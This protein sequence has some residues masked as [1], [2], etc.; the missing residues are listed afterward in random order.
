MSGSKLTFQ[1]VPQMIRLRAGNRLLFVY[2]EMMDPAVMAERVPDPEFVCTAHMESQGFI[3]NADGIVS[4]TPR[5]GFEV[6]GVVW[7]VEEIA[8]S[9]LDLLLGVPGPVERFGGFSRNL[10]GTLIVSELPGPR[11][12]PS[13][14]SCRYRESGSQARASRRLHQ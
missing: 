14:L 9:C 2:D 11:L 1:C 4:I 7:Q 5:Q 8:V 12:G 10:A 13:R 6:H 3:I